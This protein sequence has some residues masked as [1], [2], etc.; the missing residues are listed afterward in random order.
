[1]WVESSILVGNQPVA[2]SVHVLESDECDQ[3]AAASAWFAVHALD[4]APAGDSA[5]WQTF[6]ERIISPHVAFTVQ[7]E[8]VEDRSG[9][10]WPRVVE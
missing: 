8:K 7:E 1:M 5:M 3:T 2:P 6:F 10:P 9:R 4:G